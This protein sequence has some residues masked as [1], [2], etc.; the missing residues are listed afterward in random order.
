MKLD[1]SQKGANAAKPSY[2]Q[3]LIELIFF[4]CIAT[5]PLRDLSVSVAR[6][7]QLPGRRLNDYG[8]RNG[9][10]LR[11]ERLWPPSARQE[12][13]NLHRQPLALFFELG[14]HRA[15]YKVKIMAISLRQTSLFATVVILIFCLSSF[16]GPHVLQQSL[17]ADYDD[18]ASFLGYVE[19]VGMDL[20]SSYVYKV[21][22]VM[23][24]VS[25]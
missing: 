11:A 18:A 23:Q 4:T 21:N 19:G 16:G 10:H 7:A 25:C 15:S 3:T 24:G 13:T 9:S 6:A 20:S 1:Q 12:L 5:R 2:A 22:N 8:P 14:R 17:Y